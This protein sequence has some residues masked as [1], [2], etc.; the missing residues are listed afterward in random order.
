MACT[1]FSR[2]RPPRAWMFLATSSCTVSVA[3]AAVETPVS[4]GGVGT[5]VC[6]V[7]AR[8]GLAADRISAAAQLAAVMVNNRGDTVSLQE[9]NAGDERVA[10]RS[11]T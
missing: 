5:W 7:C 4:R 10:A 6:V 1:A 11:L 8:T 2:S 9:D 3:G